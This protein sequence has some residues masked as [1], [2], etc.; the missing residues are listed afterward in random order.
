MVWCPYGFVPAGNVSSSSTIQI[1]RDAN[2]WW[3]L[4]SVLVHICSVISLHSSMSKAIIISTR[5][6]E[7]G[8]RTRCLLQSLQLLVIYTFEY[9]S[10]LLPSSIRRTLE[11]C[12]RQRWETSEKW[13]GSTN[14]DVCRKH[15]LAATHGVTETPQSSEIL[16]REK[17][18]PAFPISESFCCFLG[19]RKVDFIHENLD[20]QNHRMSTE[21]AKLIVNARKHSLL[22]S[23]CN[24][25]YVYVKQHE[26]NNNSNKTVKNR[27]RE[28]ER[29]MLLCQ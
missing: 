6:F 28:R 27:E 25:G 16:Q 20:N 15:C 2:H 11:L 3:W 19:L 17:E 7:G 13:F 24:K 14:Q 21:Q 12:Q 18:S 5:V 10:V 8:C 29:E 26:R 4:L 9:L 1:L 22:N 23:F